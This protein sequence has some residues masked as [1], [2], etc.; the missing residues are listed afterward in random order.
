MFTN[1]SGKFASKESHKSIDDNNAGMQTQSQK[2]VIPEVPA[3]EN[4]SN[5]LMDEVKRLFG[6]YW[7]LWLVVIV[8]WL[9]K[10]GE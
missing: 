8:W 1:V 2:V 4:N 7:W 6:K 10:K 3:V 5:E 9:M